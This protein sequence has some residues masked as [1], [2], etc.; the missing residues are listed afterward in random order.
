MMEIAF[1]GG[2]SGAVRHTTHKISAPLRSHP[3]ADETHFFRPLMTQRSPVK[4][5]KSTHRL[6]RAAEKL[7]D[8]HF[9]PVRWSRSSANGVP[10]LLKNGAS[11]RPHCSGVPPTKIRQKTKHRSE[12]PC[13]SDARIHAVKFLGHDGRCRLMP[14]FSP[15]AGCGMHFLKKPATTM[16]SYT[17]LVASESLLRRLQQLGRPRPRKHF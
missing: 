13:Q 14:A 11:S 10:L 5:G 1:S 17:G 6:R 16:A 12:R 7:G 4:L 2:A 8:W 15:P 9:L 3:V